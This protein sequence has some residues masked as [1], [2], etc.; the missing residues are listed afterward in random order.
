MRRIHGSTTTI[1]ISNRHCGRIDSFSRRTSRPSFALS[2]ALHIEG[3]REGRALA[4]PV[5]RLL[6]KMQA[7]G[8]TGLAENARPSLRDGFD[9]CFAFSPVH[10]LLA[11]VA[12]AT[13]ERRRKRDT[14]VGVSGPRDLTVHAGSFVGAN[15]FTLR[16][17]MPTAFRCRR[18]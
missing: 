13:R 14:S 5:A 7:A 15:H 16:P 17:D 6:K 1:C 12:R 2:T 3:R 10:R 9:G 4:A 11:T 8:T 18:P